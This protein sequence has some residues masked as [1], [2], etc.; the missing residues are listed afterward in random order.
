MYCEVVFGLIRARTPNRVA[1]SQGGTPVHLSTAPGQDEPANWETS[2]GNL[3]AWGIDKKTFARLP[4]GGRDMTDAER[5]VRSLPIWKGLKSLTPLKGGV[6]NASFIVDDASGRFVAR[7][8]HDYPFHQVERAREAEAARAAHAAGLSPAV[9]HAGDGLMVVTF[10]EAR[11]YSEADVRENWEK[12]LDL[13]MRCHRD[14]G[15]LIKGQGAIFWVFQILRDYAATLEHAGHRVTPH[16]SRYLAITDELEAAQPPMPIVFG[17][18]DLL[19]T[20]FLDDGKRLWLI[21]WEYGAFG[22][23]MFDLAN[24]AAANSF[25]SDLEEKM[26]ITYFGRAPDHTLRR[27]YAAMKVA[28]AL[29]EG[30]WGMISE[31]HLAAPGVDYVAYAAEYIGRFETI[32]AQYKKDFP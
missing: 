18:Q 10:L 14:V 17:H 29:R 3:D 16:L 28:A 30:V 24:L 11:T 1:A 32:Y 27:G 12:C 7:V 21:D 2:G 23:A 13:I 31:L 19:P 25:T 4:G 6:S 5:K 9:I 15:R 8:G 26:L 20:N 22:T